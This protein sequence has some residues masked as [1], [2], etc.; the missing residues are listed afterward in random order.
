MVRKVAGCA[1]GLFFAGALG[2]SPASAAEGPDVDALLTGWARLTAGRPEQSAELAVEMLRLDAGN[3]AA[4]ELYLASHMQ[5]WGDGVALIEQYRAWHRGNSGDA[6]RRIALAMALLYGSSHNAVG[7]TRDLRSEEDLCDEA[8]EALP[9]SGRGVVVQSALA[10]AR[11]AWGRACGKRDAAAWEQLGQLATTDG[12]SAYRMLT[13]RLTEAEVDLRAVADV[14][15]RLGTD[16]RVMRLVVDFARVHPATDGASKKAAKDLRKAIEV[17]LSSEDTAVLELTSVAL[18]ALGDPRGREVAERL[19]RLDPLA[20]PELPP[21]ALVVAERASSA[22]EVLRQLGRT[23][24]FES[25]GWRARAEQVRGDALARLE[26]HEEAVLA[27]KAA[28]KAGP[29]EP[30]LPGLAVGFAASA[31]ATG[32]E[33]ALAL[34]TIDLALATLD[35]SRGVYP[36][37]MLGDVGGRSASRALR[38]ALHAAAADLLVKSG[39]QD[40]ALAAWQRA[41]VVAPSAEG[42]LRLGE[43][44]LAMD[45]PNEAAEEMIEG[46]RLGSDDTDLVERSRAALERTFFEVGYWHADG[47]LGYVKARQRASELDDAGG[48]HPLLGLRFPLTSFDRLDGD[49]LEVADTAKVL[50]VALWTTSCEGCEE[51]MGLLGELNARWGD[52][53]TAV[54]I[55][56]DEVRDTAVAF[57]AGKPKPAYHRAW[58]P[59]AGDLLRAEQ[60]PAIFVIGGNRRVVRVV[61]GVDREERAAVEAAVAAEAARARGR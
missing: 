50:V 8:Y 53:L 15:Q 43:L 49:R 2:L 60:V 4:H 21:D 51:A 48:A 56:V 44:L 22:E 25:T 12:L 24:A 11:I 36:P 23:E 47:A 27:Y 9:T 58:D 6:T 33:L 37:Q 55:N 18:T 10:H 34:E 38:G 32:K 52:E 7:F 59:R 17:H 46:L 19:R 35:A 40:E 20:H 45:R 54:A 39:R 1:V 3:L 42:H 16:P 29:R 41:L 14:E 61:L 30:H 28:L 13:W 26:R 57:L 31:L 5:G